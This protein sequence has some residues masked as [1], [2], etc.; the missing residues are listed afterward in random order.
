M[1]VALVCDWL[2]E[3]GG[4]E[5]VLL[6]LHKMFPD[7]PIYTSQYRKG[8]IDWFLDATVKTG[9]LNIFP[10]WSRRMIA[11][12]RQRYFKKLDLTEYDLVISVTGCDAKLVKA[13]KHICYCHVPTQYYWGKK[14][15]YMK[16]PGFGL[17]NPIARLVYK[18]KLPKLQKIDRAAA[19]NPTEFV[20]IS[21]YAKAEIKKY[22]KREAKIVYP[23]VNTEIFAQAVENKNTKKGK[24]QTK[25]AYN[26]TTKIQESQAQKSEQNFYT[27]L[28]NVENFYDGN[29]YI[30]FSRQVN[31]KN[32]DLIIKA[33][34][35]YKAPLLLVGNGPENSRLKKLAGSSPFIKFVDFLPKEKLAV[36]ASKAKAFIF[37]S[38]EP[39]GIAPIEAMS[40]GCPVIALK[41]GGALDYIKDGK[42]GLFFERTSVASLI[43]TLKKFEKLKKQHPRRVI[44]N[45]KKVSSSVER[46]SAS[47]FRKAMRKVINETEN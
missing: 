35:K 20:T 26:K 1:K 29:F 9:W 44:F 42:N 5:L 12:L 38:E 23:P 22:Y 2:T 27:T 13:K 14:D 32:L 33:C 19:K 24:S 34:K 41:K 6:E 25:K 46:F 47:N 28:E 16:N 36:L 15:F 10:A 4:A 8:R 31:W 21:N 30:N 43:K 18:E 37:P 7:A 40:A 39:F 17:L 11:P 3:V 45:K